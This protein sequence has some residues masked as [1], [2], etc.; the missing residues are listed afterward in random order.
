MAP[1]LRSTVR[2]SEDEQIAQQLK[3]TE[4]RLVDHYAGHGRM[5]ENQVRRTFGRVSERF[6]NARIRTFLPIL[7]ER[8][9]RRELEL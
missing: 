6:R 3:E 4:T 2:H 9:V 1:D 7:V 5:T 8:A